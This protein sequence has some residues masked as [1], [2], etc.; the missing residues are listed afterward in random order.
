MKLAAPRL[1]LDHVLTEA[2]KFVVRNAGKV[3]GLGLLL[4]GLPELLFDASTILAPEP[5]AGGNTLAS[6]VIEGVRSS[7]FHGGVAYLFWQELEDRRVGWR[8]LLT[9]DL[10]VLGLLLGAGLLMNLAVDGGFYL[11]SF[12]GALFGL[13]LLYLAGALIF[14]LVGLAVVTVVVERCGVGAALARAFKLARGARLKLLFLYVLAIGFGLG[15]DELA[16]QVGLG[17]YYDSP[18]PFGLFPALLT[19]ATASTLSEVYLA[20]MVAAAYFELRRL[21]E[22]APPPDPA[23]VFRLERVRR[24]VS[25]SA[26][27]TRSRLR[28]CRT[29]PCGGVRTA[30]GLPAARAGLRN[31]RR[32]I[33]RRRPARPP[34]RS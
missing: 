9:P 11:F 6:F 24:S 26:A 34:S 27:R 29:C 20:T 12:V 8:E 31:R 23:T 1:R 7:L 32:G 21:R 10:K 14:P 16:V 28:S 18:R 25:G 22:A 13:P 15:A 2:L 4:V 5:P 3:F 19:C 33:G 17:T 30:A